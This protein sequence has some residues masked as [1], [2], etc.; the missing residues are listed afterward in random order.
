M[1]RFP[2]CSSR[3][4]PG[5]FRSRRVPS[6]GVRWAALRASADEVITKP[7]PLAELRDATLRAMKRA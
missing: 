1:P 7:V 3:R 6:E 4:T 2:T 5:L